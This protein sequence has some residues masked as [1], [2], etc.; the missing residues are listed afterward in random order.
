MYNKYVL[1]LFNVLRLLTCAS[2]NATAISTSLLD[3]IYIMGLTIITM[4][5]GKYVAQ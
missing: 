4:A 3:N 5:I 1:I 2:G